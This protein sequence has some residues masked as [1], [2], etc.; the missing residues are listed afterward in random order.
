M[1]RRLRL[2]TLFVSLLLQTLAVATECFANQRFP[3]VVQSAASP[4]ENTGT[5]I[6]VHEASSALYVA[7]QVTSLQTDFSWPWPS[8]TTG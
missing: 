8:T 2:L 6:A 3:K 7:G 1:K 4:S 5:A